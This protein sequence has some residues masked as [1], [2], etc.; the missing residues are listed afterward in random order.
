MNLTCTWVV[1]PW[2]GSAGSD[3]MKDPGGLLYDL[4]NPA[5]GAAADSDAS[6]PYDVAI[7][8]LGASPARRLQMLFTMSYYEPRDVLI[9]DVVHPLVK[10]GNFDKDGFPFDKP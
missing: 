9:G 10:K 3:P 7:S 2:A 6:Y 8:S 1:H 4:L 5:N